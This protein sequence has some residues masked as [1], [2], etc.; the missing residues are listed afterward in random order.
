MPFCAFKLHG[1]FQWPPVAKPDQALSKET[2]VVEI[3]YDNRPDGKPG[4]VAF[5]R[6]CPKEHAGSPA[7]APTENVFALSDPAA[8][9]G[10]RT[11]SDVAIWIHPRPGKGDGGEKV[12]FRGAFLFTQI[13]YR[14]G[15]AA[16]PRLLRWPLVPSCKYGQGTREVFSELVVGQPKA[17]PD[18]RFNLHLPTPF[19]QTN[20]TGT[21]VKAFPISAL[22][23]SAVAELEEAG[24]FST[25]VAGPIDSG[26]E[27]GWFSF[28]PET[29]P[30]HR[31]GGFGFAPNDDPASGQFVQYA[32]NR[33]EGDFFRTIDLT[34]FW[35]GLASGW[36]PGGCL[37]ALEHMGF[38]VDENKSL[39]LE[40]TNP[41]AFSLRLPQA[42][43]LAKADGPEAWTLRYRFSLSAP[44][45]E[46]SA[47]DIAWRDK[48]FDL[49]LE[50]EIG[51]Y[52]ATSSST[53]RLDCE[54]RWTITEEDV[55]SRGWNPTALLCLHWSEEI[56][57]GMLADTPVLNVGQKKLPAFRSGM[58]AAA[59][60]ALQDAPKSLYQVESAQP[61]SFLPELSLSTKQ[62]VR[63]ALYAPAVRL[64]GKTG[65]LDWP[66]HPGST[67][68][69][70]RLSL[71]S[72]SA[73]MARW[74]GAAPQLR[75]RAQLHSFFTGT[76]DAPTPALELTLVHQKDWI[77]ANWEAA[78]K[79][80]PYFAAFDISE[81]KCGRWR[82]RI[83][84][85]DFFEPDGFTR[86]D[87][88]RLLAGGRGT[89]GDALR[90]VRPQNYPYP[91]AAQLELKL[92]FRLATVLGPDTGRTDD[93]REAPLL[94][95][96]ALPAKFPGADSKFY[97]NVIESVAP[98]GD[99]NVDVELIEDAP[100]SEDMAYVVISREP[101][102]VARF[103]HK[104]LSARG[105][106]EL[107]KVAYYSGADRIWQY[108]N[109]TPHYR[110]T[111]PP[112][113]VGESADKPRRLELHD[114]LGDP[115]KDDPGATMP[116]D[117]VPRPYRIR[118]TPGKTAED[119]KPVFDSLQRRAVE[120]RLTPS[121]EIWVRPSDV[122]RRFFTPEWQSH[123]LFR[124][125]GEL[126]LGVALTAFR[127][128]FLYGLPVGVEVA[129]ESGVARRARIA[130]IEALTGRFLPPLPGS[131]KPVARWNSLR[132][133]LLQRPERLE[134]WA[135]DP[136]AVV[137]FAPARFSSG[138]Q[139]ALRRTALFRAPLQALDNTDIPVV[140][141]DPNRVAPIGEG[142]SQPTFRYHPQ[143]LSGGALW[144]VESA[145]LF[146]AL[147]AN[148]QSSGGTLD[149][150]AFS[151]V[152]GDAVQ[153][154][155]FLGGKV[156]IISRT[157][158]GFIESQRVE[159]IGR[160]GALWHRAKHV[161]VYER[162][163]NPSSQFA[164]EY[165]EDSQ[166]TRSRRPILRK[167]REFVEILQ[168]ERAYPDFAQAS[169]RTAGC[170]ERV[171]FNSTIINVDSAWSRD[172]EDYGWEIPLWNRAAAQRRP[173]VYPM[174][175]AAFCSHSE[176]DGEMP[177][178]AQECQDCDYLYF[179]GDFRTPG[180]NTDA[181][182]ERL[183]VDYVNMPAASTLAK[184]VDQ[185]SSQD[186][187]DD[188]GPARRRR[189]V[190]R[191][192]P[193]MRRFTWRLAPA[194]RKVAI[195]AGRSASPVYVG[196]E[197][198]T[199]MRAGVATGA[200]K[201]FE[202]V[203]GD[204]VG[205]SVNAAKADAPPE[206]Y[207]P[208][209]GVGVEGFKAQ[210][211]QR[212][213]GVRNAK[214]QP[215]VTDS[216]NELKRW[217]DENSTKDLKS[218]LYA[219][220]DHL[221]SAKDVF[222]GI[223][224]ASDFLKQGRSHCD[225]MKAD[226]L[227]LLHGKAMLV[228][229][230]IRDWE[231]DIQLPALTTKSDLIE[232][233]TQLLVDQT[234]PAFADAAGT[235]AGAREDIKA[236]QAILA[237]L[238]LELGAA[239]TDTLSRINEYRRS[240]DHTKPW[241]PDRRKQFE[242]GLFALGSSLAE[243]VSARV[244]EARQRLGMEL[245][246]LSQQ[247]GGVVAA[248]LRKAD[249]E[250]LNS[251]SEVS[252]YTVAVHRILDDARKKL[253]PA[254][255]D[256]V[257]EKLAE[258]RN[259][260][261]N[262]DGIG[263]VDRDDLIALLEPVERLAGDLREAAMG[264]E[265]T[266]I[267][268]ENRFGNYEQAAI[269]GLKEA[270]LMLRRM[271]ANVQN[272]SALLLALAKASADLQLGEVVLRVEAARTKY[273]DWSKEVAA[274][275][276]RYVQAA[277]EPIDYVVGAF[278]KVVREALTLVHSGVQGAAKDADR[279]AD[280]IAT[281]MRAAENV[282][283]PGALLETVVK[284]RVFAP[285]LQQL[286]A[287]LPDSL[288]EMQLADAKILLA[289]V[290]ALSGEAIR[291][292]DAT[293]MGAVGEITELCSS[294]FDVSDSAYA[295]CQ[296]LGNDVGQYIDNQIAEG[297]RVLD[298]LFSEA[299]PSINKILA[300]VTAVDQAVRR[301]QNDLVRSAE[302]ARAYGD[303]VLDAV[304]K[305]GSGGILAAPSNILR[306]YSA[307]CSAP[308]LAALKADI[309]RLRA[310]FDE[311][312]DMVDTT[313]VTA[314]FNRFGDEL[315]ALGLS[316]PFDG[317]GQ[318][319]RLADPSSLD[320]GKAIRSLGG[321]NLEHLFK[322]YKLP[323]SASDSIVL[324]HEFNVKK[325]RAW[326]QIDINVPL[327]GRRS[328]F[329]VEVFKADF[330]DTKLTA[331]VR[332]EVTEDDPNVT[333][334]GYGRID[335]A[336]DLAVAGQ[337]M[338]RFEKFALSFT[339]ESGLEVQFDPK[340]I[341]INP[342][343]QFVQDFLAMLFPDEIGG[344]RVI[345]RD[346]IPVGLEHEF[347]M[348]PISLNFGTSGISNISISNTFQLTAYPDFVLADQFWL[349]RP[350]RPFIFSFFIIGG[351]G[352]VHVEAEYKPF[353]SDLVV[354]VEA[355]AGGSAALAF[356]FGPFSGQ[357][358]ITLSVTISYQK[359][360]G[361]PGGGLSIGAMLVIAGY[362]NVA[363]IATVGIYLMLRMTYRESG[364]VDAD[365]TL[366]VTIRISRFFKITARANVQYKLRDGQT[367][368]QSMARFDSQME[369]GQ[370]ANKVKQLKRARG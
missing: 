234:R 214:T 8:W 86:A 325:G 7:P 157:R 184:I 224:S 238:S 290:S 138:V 61:Q 115:D 195:N 274:S 129:K 97:L 229:A 247:M 213:E 338:V 35:A 147:A 58:L 174:P 116:A 75:L 336:I 159:V 55:W 63:F 13:E 221:T 273:E 368:T 203:L 233:L 69:P 307:V 275:A 132:L 124:Q 216:L 5:L 37:R 304:G 47:G 352:Y 256:E 156:T 251:I 266:V 140:P 46:G 88:G 365:G 362:V 192:L 166:R 359:R 123:E 353:R 194:N 288:G 143:G 24:Q 136:D 39:A 27:R 220:K 340:N 68:T 104:P 51:G 71:A 6:W 236:A 361:S 294:L 50:E 40:N 131:S 160:V 261:E 64:D 299:N 179:F 20:L 323:R 201:A 164:P 295:Y 102:G 289:S 324:T 271:L 291:K 330:V 100:A 31:L 48:Q 89:G 249:I 358:F 316:L 26:I 239:L 302:S 206:H 59:A 91:F 210:F 360:I 188:S 126:G 272:C 161:V 258:A 149:D 237:D 283:K 331:R 187:M 280:D 105:S 370:I 202:A 127:A 254:R 34:R 29:Y 92:N 185:R 293:A 306:L 173:Q 328:L 244:E 152:G 232:S 154:A 65:T 313:R 296:A 109:A 339:R 320:I 211:S 253:D 66:P 263:N 53:L 117:G 337:S 287:P 346:G 137:E 367:K 262:A 74:D 208:A 335:S 108:A 80:D 56:P 148:P 303:R 19:D 77:A 357:V 28:I 248:A 332:F 167:V 95:P 240:Y 314:L 17:N 230:L 96:L 292:L 43:S 11:K 3:H 181:W 329:S 78:D 52:L 2:G 62:R 197:S 225:H 317:I 265:D 180:A 14:S 333:Q 172:V 110:Y 10:D 82:G 196:L 223:Q 60:Q 268:I 190:S 276:D 16:E 178:V 168:R 76:P 356:S 151:P 4:F 32:G 284:E 270:G 301:I 144:P 334:T 57:K 171:R 193:G 44:K 72:A 267:S 12:A 73:D 191:F 98:F 142:S 348:P 114:W 120:F 94:I 277:G 176:G 355:G 9:F 189:P 300:S 207:W 119:R 118:L 342:S 85:L 315:K 22:F 285:V 322:N 133:A 252:N 278:E 54:V 90:L 242:Q 297:K 318:R 42:V 30:S 326:V 257:L 93:D 349:S 310:S 209:D 246:D 182:P 226:A 327:P 281:A 345:K 139:F 155:L 312:S 269:D 260:I 308:E 183:G 231:A 219:L 125:R 198:I 84:S 347:A 212:I 146:R 309:D 163:V 101:F 350:E 107:G 241:S 343:L 235:V 354:T 150:V 15:D 33:H 67:A 165:E 41:G 121:A 1:D 282:L 83:S 113:G 369:E 21:A 215:E 25:L 286:L 45:G 222:I 175:D 134:V 200:E 344:M 128:E 243:N 228:E 205:F 49:A 141:G 204:I 111:L 158:N 217:W 38:R 18:F 112:Q 279:V 87:S 255:F 351:T 145:N 321:A 170:L 319:L 199:F 153:K 130:D 36:T 366:S 259:S 122:K 186:P 177:T 311:L 363:S 341:R 23:S 81:A 70:L 169:A 106:A 162:T 79:G 227:G 135:H 218:E 298:K 103:A 99:R 250:Q 364:Q 264:G 245:G 305:L